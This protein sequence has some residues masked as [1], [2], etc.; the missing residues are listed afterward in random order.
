LSNKGFILWNIEISRN[1]SSSFCLVEFTFSVLSKIWVS[2]ISFNS[3]CSF[4]IFKS[5]IHPASIASFTILITIHNLL[6][7]ETCFIL[8]MNSKLS[9][10]IGSSWKCPAWS[11]LSLIFNISNSTVFSPIPFCRWILLVCE[12]VFINSVEWGQSWFKFWF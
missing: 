10:N 3:S 11:A 5:S 8:M 9:F 2:F 6:F 12:V 7:T 1:L 4:N